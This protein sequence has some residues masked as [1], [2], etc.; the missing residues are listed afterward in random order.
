MGRQIFSGGSTML[1]LSRKNCS[2]AERMKNMSQADRLAVCRLPRRHGVT[3][4][5]LAGRAGAGPT[6]RNRAAFTLIELL[7]V[8]AIIAVLIALLVP[9]VQKVRHAAARTQ[10]INNLKQLA[11]A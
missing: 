8:I 9:A 6:N 3:H 10:S 11:L 1:D 2:Q 4:S 7:V 5:P